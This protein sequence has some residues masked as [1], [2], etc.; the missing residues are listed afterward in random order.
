MKIND[1]LASAINDQ[2]NFE[3]QSAYLYLAMSNFWRE[4]GRTGFANWFRVQSR[5]EMAHAE[6]FMDYVHDRD[7][8]VELK[9]IENVKQTWT[10]IHETFA[11][12]LAHEQTVTR[13]I[14]ALYELAENEKDYASRQ[15]L[16]AY[17]AEQIE[18][19]SNVQDIIDNLDLVGEDGTGI[20][21][22]DRELAGRTYTAPQLR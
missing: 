6:A 16:N 5:E 19:E 10:S 22:I 4:K 3:L 20:L 18:E 13:R 12:T 7:G 11:D 21:Q 2:I 9:P 8:V 14:H 15:M 17:I 1:K